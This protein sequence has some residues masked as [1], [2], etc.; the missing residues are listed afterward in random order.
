MS[1]NKIIR[2]I[3]EGDSLVLANI[4][5]NKGLL[6]YLDSK[7]PPQI[8]EEYIRDGIKKDIQNKEEKKVY[9][10]VV[11]DGNEV[12]GTISL[13]NPDANKQAYEIGYFIGKDYWGT[14]LAT[15]AIKEIVKWG[16]EELKVKR[17]FA[18]V[19]KKNIASNRA[20]EKAG[21]KKKNNMWEIKIKM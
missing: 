15:E 11:L 4:L 16:L 13:Y 2:P 5:N 7:H 20:L 8:T 12:R 19:D 17:I 1:P 21:F 14:G 6:K 9:K 3:K 18:E 10:F